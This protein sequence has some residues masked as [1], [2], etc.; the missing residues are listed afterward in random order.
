MYL[1]NYQLHLYESLKNKETKTG[2][3]DYLFQNI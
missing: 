1:Y 2:R 3:Q